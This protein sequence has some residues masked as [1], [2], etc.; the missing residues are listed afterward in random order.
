MRGF[1]KIF[2][3]RVFLFI[4]IAFFLALF[5]AGLFPNGLAGDDGLP[6][7]AIEVQE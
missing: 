5:L 3:L 6:C 2:M 4:S 7:F 1:I